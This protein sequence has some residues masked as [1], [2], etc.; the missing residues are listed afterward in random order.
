MKQIEIDN[1]IY[2]YKIDELGNVYNKNNKI[3]K[4]YKNKGYYSYKIRHKGKYIH[5]T[6]HRP[7]FNA[8]SPHKSPVNRK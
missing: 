3:V 1:E 8:P 6:Q 4:P 7:Q 5:L 2:D